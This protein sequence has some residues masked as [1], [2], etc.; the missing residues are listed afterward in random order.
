MLDREGFD[1]WACEFDDA[2]RESEEE[3]SYPFAGYGKVMECIF[4]EITEK[5]RASVLDLGFGTGT[6]SSR[7]Y[8]SGCDIYGQDF[9]SEMI[10]IARKKMP[11]AHLY[12]G[13]F[14]KGLAEPLLG[15]K[16]DFIVST[17]ALHHL[18]DDGKVMLI[19]KLLGL[20]EDGGKI[21]IG[22]VAFKTRRD[23]EKCRLDTGD[24]WDDAEHYF[25][26]D[27]LRDSFPNLRFRKISFCAG[28]ITIGF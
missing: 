1:R 4:R 7:L 12:E 15:R 18:T 3:N 23:M 8:A 10:G 26:A 14:S 21:I 20:L 27:E 25:V 5:K 13:D 28:V 2:V 19:G 11:K 17:Y 16:Y 9:S 6:L 24:E 22:D